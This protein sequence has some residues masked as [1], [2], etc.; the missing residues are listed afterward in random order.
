MKQDVKDNVARDRTQPVQTRSPGTAGRAAVAVAAVPTS[1]AARRRRRRSPLCIT[2]QLPP[3]LPTEPPEVPPA[4]EP[5][6]DSP[7]V[8]PLWN[9]SPIRCRQQARTTLRDRCPAEQP[10]ARLRK[11][12]DSE[13]AE[14]LDTVDIY[15]LSATRA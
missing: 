10:D 2:P 7:H 9:P 4:V 11:R 3:D 12:R 14:K 8:S 13:L 1:R 6:T 15:D 5:G